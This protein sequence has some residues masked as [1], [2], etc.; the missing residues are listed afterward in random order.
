MTYD[1]AGNV[2]Q[3]TNRQRFHNATG[4]GE[5][6]TPS[7][8]QPKARVT[9]QA[10]YSDELGRQ[11]AVAEY[12]T[13][14]G[15]TFDRAAIVPNRADTILV[16]STEYDQ[17]GN[18][19]KTVDPAG[20]EHRTVFDARGRK[21]K[22]IHNYVDGNPATG[23]ADEDVTVEMAYNSDGNIQTL[24]A[25]NSSTG[26]QTTTYIYGTSLADSGV[27]TST[28]KRAE[29]YPD[30][31][32]TT[33]LGNGSDGVY[34]RIELKYDRQQAL[35]EVKDQQETVHA[36]DFDALGRQTQDRVTSLGSG[37]DGTVRRIATEYDGLGRKSRIT[38][39]DNPTVGS[40]SIVNDLAFVYDDFGQLITEY[41]EHGGAV[42]T[43][44]SLKV[45]YAYATARPARSA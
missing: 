14:G 3:T 36:F 41:Q 16:T 39:Y 9:Y 45:Q 15:A 30:S 8:S 6:T 7:G 18:A 38:S 24:T 4:A 25:K 5:L 13:Y 2:L 31:D 12:G 44:T 22:A 42:N 35:V 26:D 29:I 21:V 43:S 40:G 19:C 10:T 23:N 20:K 28:L 1:D 32:D 27:A 11:I 34:D 17:A 33:G 37:V